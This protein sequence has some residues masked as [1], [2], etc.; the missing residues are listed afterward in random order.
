MV[1][2]NANWTVSR[3]DLAA[4]ELM[5]V[6][7]D[8]ERHTMQVP[9]AQM[10]ALLAL[11]QAPDVLLLWDPAGPTLIA[12]NLVGEWIEP[13]WAAGEPEEPGEPDDPD[14]LSGRTLR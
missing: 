9:A 14:G 11:T 1:Y 13:A 5:V 2:V 4:F 6:T 12:A 3:A 10:A 7:E 8:D